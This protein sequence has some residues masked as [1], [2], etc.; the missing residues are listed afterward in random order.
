MQQDG[1]EDCLDAWITEAQGGYP[2][3]VD[4]DRLMQGIESGCS[5]RTVVTDA[6]DVEKTSGGVEADLL[7]VIE[8]DQ[9]AL[10]AEVIR[11]V[12]HLLRSQ[13]TAF[14][15]VLLDTRMLVI[16]MQRRL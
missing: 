11:V 10:D 15:E 9:S 7:E 8:V 12:D 4:D 1:C 3:F 13:G 5:D 6:L 14:L 16:H 2:T